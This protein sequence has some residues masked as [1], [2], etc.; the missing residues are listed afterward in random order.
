MGDVHRALVALGRERCVPAH[1]PVTLLG[2]LFRVVEQAHVALPGSAP[3]DLA[4][5]QHAGDVADLVLGEGARRELVVP[6]HLHGAL[7]DWEWHWA[8]CRYPVAL[9]LQLSVQG[10]LLDNLTY[11]I[12]IAEIAVSRVDVDLVGLRI[13]LEHR[14]LAFAQAL[15]VLRHVLR[16]DH[17]DRLLVSVGIDRLRAGEKHVVPAGHLSQVFAGEFGD[18]AVRIAGTLGTGT[19]EF[20]AE[21][22]GFLGAYLGVGAGDKA[23][24][25]RQRYG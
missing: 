21:L 17:D 2:L 6:Q 9:V 19:G 16:G 18:A 11:I 3:S 24:I 20:L 15:G 8:A 12:W 14:L 10:V 7:R 5:G 1:R 23:C 4:I 13:T 22:G 25:D